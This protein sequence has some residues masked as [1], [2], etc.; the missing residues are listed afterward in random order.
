MI[1][2]AISPRRVLNPISRDLFTAA[3]NSV[4]RVKETT[5]KLR[6]GTYKNQKSSQ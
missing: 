4:S 1:K 3:K 5:K 2:P 6:K